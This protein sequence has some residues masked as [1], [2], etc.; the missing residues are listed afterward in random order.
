M[1]TVKRYICWF[2]MILLVST[3]ASAQEEEGKKF[4][5]P[6]RISVG[7]DNTWV[8]ITP[9]GKVVKYWPDGRTMFRLG[10]NGRSTAFMPA[11]SF[12]SPLAVN[13]DNLSRILILDQEEE[14]VYIFSYLGEL[15]EKVDVNSMDEGLEYMGLGLKG[16]NNVVPGAPTRYYPLASFVVK[17]E[18][19][20]GLGEYFRIYSGPKSSVYCAYRKTDSTTIKI[21]SSTGEFIRQYSIP[22]R[23]WTMVVAPD[24]TTFDL[25]WTEL[26]T[27]SY[28]WRLTKRNSTATSSTTL[29]TWAVTDP[30][31]M[32]EIG[33]V[34]AKDGTLYH[35][36]DGRFELGDLYYLERY[37]GTGTYLGD[38]TWG[39][40]EIPA[41]LY[42]IFP[43]GKLL[44]RAY[45]PFPTSALRNYTYST[46]T[47]NTWG[48]Q[49]SRMGMG[50]IGS[51]SS[52]NF[53]MYARGRSPVHFKIFNSNHTVYETVGSL[54]RT[55]GMF[56]KPTDHLAANRNKFWVVDGTTLKLVERYQYPYYRL[57]STGGVKLKGFVKGL[58]A[59]EL[60]KVKVRIEGVDEDGF[61]IYG[62]T[63]L[64]SNGKYIFRKFPKNASYS[65]SLVGLDYNK[66]NHTPLTITGKT[67]KNEKLE[68]IDV[69]PWEGDALA[70]K[71]VVT[72][73]DKPWDPVPGVKITCGKNVVYSRYDG[74]FIVPV[75]AGTKK[76]T[77][78]FEREYFSLR[79]ATKVIKLK[80]NITTIAKV[81]AF[82]VPDK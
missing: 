13:Q 41:Y 54:P 51:D 27:Y 40:A 74:S 22:A 68:T 77:I 79:P 7:C 55:M 4:L 56:I 80:E 75:A 71:G 8:E 28:Q 47:W 2:I 35:F 11:K 36:Y 45:N 19:D 70:V 17:K 24:G 37:N 23:I 62:E 38:R 69:M 6:E 61:S 25:A 31:H 26:G 32:E 29:K 73:N 12:G 9:D 49:E 64:K 48:A 60:A 21:Y 14:A 67:S 72:M 81:R 57:T 44:F 15:E 76:A 63:K 52:V 46:D 43:S 1:C 58:T 82:Y 3:M 10:K 16:H 33:L 59:D 20:P 30:D 18:I 65:I 78:T 53:Y 42:D 34:Q 39:Y 66:Y 5:D 50:S